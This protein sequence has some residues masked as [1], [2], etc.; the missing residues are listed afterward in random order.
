[1]RSW[2]CEVFVSW[3]ARRSYAAHI[4]LLLGKKLLSYLPLHESLHG[5]LDI[6]ERFLRTISWDVGAVVFENYL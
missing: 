6:A 2:L 3:V 5:Y 1:M 4:C